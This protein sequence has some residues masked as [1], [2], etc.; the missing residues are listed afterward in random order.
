[1][2]HDNPYSA[3]AAPVDDAP[4]T[5]LPIRT[6]GRW[7][8]WFNWLVDS[9]AMAVIWGLLAGASEL[10]GVGGWW[11]WRD[12]LPFWMDYLLG[13]PVSLLYY[14][15]MEGAFGVTLG[16]LCTGT[17]VVDEDGR[18]IGF[19]QALLRSLCREIPFNAFSL[20]MSDDRVIRG[21]HDSLA[22]TY[23]V[24]RRPMAAQ[25]MAQDTAPVA[26]AQA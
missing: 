4:Q 19:G 2:Q 14:T 13:I 17:C 5:R 6:A 12:D 21:W 22:R 11:V 24:L 1:M 15:A 9:F 23:V 3:P 25:D 20:L 26:S 7:R 16:K 18:R 10:T 8:R